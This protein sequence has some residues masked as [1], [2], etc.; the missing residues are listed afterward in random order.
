MSPMPFKHHGEEEEKVPF[1]SSGPDQDES[2]SAHCPSE[3]QKHSGKMPPLRRVT[4]IIGVSLL[5]GLGLSLAKDLSLSTSCMRWAHIPYDV[6][7]KITRTALNKRQDGSLRNAT[8]SASTTSS[9]VVG[10]SI[11]S[12]RQYTPS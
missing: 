3:V 8:T 9:A 10:P 11:S 12:S 6:P 7:T 4:M 2:A 5:V 1:I